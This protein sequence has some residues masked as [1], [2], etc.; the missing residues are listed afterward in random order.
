LIANSKLPSP[1]LTGGEVID[2][3]NGGGEGESDDGDG[4]AGWVVHEEKS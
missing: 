1:S 2:G 4:F 3:P